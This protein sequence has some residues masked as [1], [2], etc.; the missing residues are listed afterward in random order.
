[1][2]RKAGKMALFFSMERPKN[3]ELTFGKSF[4]VYE[5]FR[6]KNKTVAF[7]DLSEF[8]AKFLKEF[9]QEERVL[10]KILLL[11]SMTQCLFAS[12]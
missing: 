9:M 1:M 6:S 2:A 4:Y 11:N 10:E 12:T 3:V 7:K 5:Y 8:K